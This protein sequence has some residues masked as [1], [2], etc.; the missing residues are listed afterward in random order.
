[1][2]ILFTYIA[3]GELQGIAPSKIRGKFGP[4]QLYGTSHALKHTV[5]FNI[6]I[7]ENS[8]LKKLNE[9]VFFL[10]HVV[11]SQNK[12]QA[13]KSEDE[14]DELDDQG[15]TK[16]SIADSKCSEIETFFESS[17]EFSDQPHSR[18]PRSSSS[19]NYVQS[20]RQHQAQCE[21]E[22]SQLAVEAEQEYLEQKAQDDGK[23]RSKFYD[24]SEQVGDDTKYKKLMKQLRRRRSMRRQLKNHRKI[25]E[26]PAK[27]KQQ[28]KEWR[29]EQRQKFR[30]EVIESGDESS[31]EESGDSNEGSDQSDE[32]DEQYLAACPQE[33]WERIRKKRRH[34]RIMEE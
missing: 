7:L 31:G 29:K 24:I 6:C 26:L 20:I 19:R 1:M 2:F 25:K 13:V 32:P 11:Q 27:V 4:T 14:I 18:P 15:D 30:D 22:I 17:D 3:A 5:S 21:R 33:E 28:R 16:I 9:H 10:S 12:N 8:I 34:R 23:P